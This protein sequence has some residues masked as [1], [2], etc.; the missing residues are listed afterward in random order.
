VRYK[1]IEIKMKY[2]GNTDRIKDSQKTRMRK[3]GVVDVSCHVD[4]LQRNAWQES[5]KN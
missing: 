2:N 1:E 4:K 5:D 3:G